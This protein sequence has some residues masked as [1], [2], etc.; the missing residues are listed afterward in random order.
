MR[1]N[2]HFRLGW[3][4]KVSFTYFL[5][6]ENQ[7]NYTGYDGKNVVQSF[8]GKHFLDT[9]TTFLGTFRN[10]FGTF[11]TF[12]ISLEPFS[13][14]SEQLLERRKNSGVMKMILTFRIEC[15]KKFRKFG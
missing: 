1:K 4:G 7:P 15:L 10:F 8:G 14:F 11:G 9:F 13:I 6:L 12:S 5:H 3:I 2:D